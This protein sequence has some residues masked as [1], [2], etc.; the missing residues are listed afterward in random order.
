MAAL[1]ATQ[2]D[3]RIQAKLVFPE[4]VEQAANMLTTGAI[5]AAFLS[6]SAVIADANRWDV[7][8][9]LH[10]ALP[11]IGVILG[12]TKRPIAADAVRQQLLGPVGQE[13]LK[14]HGYSPPTK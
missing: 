4:N 10:P 3:A 13:L 8:E 7:P 6:P 1:R 12:G 9:G 11:Q 14:R 2:F 5:D